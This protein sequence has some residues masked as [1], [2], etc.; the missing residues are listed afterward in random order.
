VSGTSRP[1]RARWSQSF[2]LPPPDSVGGHAIELTALF[3]SV[4]AILLVACYTQLQALAFPVTVIAL[5]AGVVATFSLGGMIGTD[6]ATYQRLE[7]DLA[8]T[9][10]AHI[11]S[12][13]APQ[14]DAPLAGVWRAYV[15][16]ADE[17]RRV[18]RVHAYSFGP[19]LWGTLVSLA[20][21][22]LAGLGLLSA[23]KDVVGLAILVEFFGFALLLLGTTTL[24]LAVGYSDEVPGFQHF[25]ARRW[26]RNSARLPAVEEALTSVPWLPEF[27]RGVRES[28][29]RPADSTLMWISQ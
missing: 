4:Y 24:M 5:L 16:V 22:L 28:R 11:G 9:V 25:S 8:R 10:L 13:D 12:N 19:Y 7:L 27:H 6:V 29:T 20:A 15:T 14:P 26:Q 21:A 1:S 23:D 3:A 2:T 18:A 17:S